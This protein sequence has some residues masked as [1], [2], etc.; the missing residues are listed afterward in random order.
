MTIQRIC[1]RHVDVARPDESVQVAAERMRQH[2]V[3]CLVVVDDLRRPIGVVTD[4]DLAL[5]VLAEG[6]NPYVTTIQAAMTCDVKTLPIEA[7]IE[8]A[9]RLMREGGFRR[10]PIV[11]R[12][13]S[14]VGLVTMDDIVMLLV[15]E[16]CQVGHLIYGETPLAAAKKA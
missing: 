9:L 14:L 15:A 1:Q 7:G 3:G 4:R 2:T 5:R 10:V 13:G 8:Q 12:E 16:L 11:D 6:K